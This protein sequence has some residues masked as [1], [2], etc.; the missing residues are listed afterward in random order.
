MRCQHM[1]ERNWAW[2][3]PG[4]FEDLQGASERETGYVV[5]SRGLNSESRGCRSRGLWGLWTWVTWPALFHQDHSVFHLD[6]DNKSLRRA[7]ERNMMTLLQE[8]REGWWWFAQSA[9]SRFGE[10]KERMWSRSVMSDYLQP[11]VA[12]QAPLFMGFYREKSWS[13]LPFSSP[14]DLLTQGSNPVSHAA[15]W[16]F[17]IWATRQAGIHGF[18][19]GNNFLNLLMK[20]HWTDGIL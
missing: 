1:R 17:T 20:L 8:P 4:L 9:S 15:G 16:L 14:G 18:H 2:A 10:K 6:N 7:E 5:G 12:C 3:V 19:V 13:G 11:H